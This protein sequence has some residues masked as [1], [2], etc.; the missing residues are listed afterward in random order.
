[1]EKITIIIPTYNRAGTLPRTLYRID[2]QTVRDYVCIIIDD[3][4]TE[5][6]GELVGKMSVGHTTWRWGKIKGMQKPYSID[7]N[8]C[9]GTCLAMDNGGDITVFALTEMDFP[10]IGFVKIDVEGFEYDVFKG[11]DKFLENMNLVLCI[12][13]RDDN[14]Y[15][16]NSLLNSYGYT[17]VENIGGDYLYKKLG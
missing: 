6:T 16:V 4:S 10:E 2:K 3:G 5:D 12:E 14:F 8:N 11:G 7:R 1:M 17:M 13:T 9:G 15:K